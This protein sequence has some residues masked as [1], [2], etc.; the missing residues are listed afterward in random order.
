MSIASSWAHPFS[1]LKTNLDGS[2]YAIIIV[3]VDKIIDTIMK[4]QTFEGH[5]KYEVAE[6]S[7]IQHGKDHAGQL[8]DL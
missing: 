8:L 1:S 5:L 3:E 2:F 7:H 6:V 4:Y